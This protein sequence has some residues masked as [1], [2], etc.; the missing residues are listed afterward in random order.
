MKI[1]FYQVQLHL[2]V[3]QALGSRADLKHVVVVR[4]MYTRQQH[5]SCAHVLLASL[6][7]AVFKFWWIDC[8][9][10]AAVVGVEKQ[11]ARVS[12]SQGPM[13]DIWAWLD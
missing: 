2:Q 5:C 4:R 3:P 7:Y 8:D 9:L 12:N 13:A 10:S 11:A 1:N 6:M